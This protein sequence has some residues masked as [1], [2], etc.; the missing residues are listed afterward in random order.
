[1]SKRKAPLLLKE[2]FPWTKRLPQFIFP[3]NLLPIC[4]LY[5]RGTRSYRRR[6]NLLDAF[7]G[8]SAEIFYE[9]LQAE[10]DLSW[11]KTTWRRGRQVV[12]QQKKK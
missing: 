4:S 10:C 3:H 1:M 7:Y 8:G 6:G 5:C 12:F 9:V 2:L 11:H